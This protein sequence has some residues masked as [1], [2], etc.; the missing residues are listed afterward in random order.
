[1]DEFSSPS[2]QVTSLPGKGLGMV[3]SRNIH[4]GE[5]I[6]AEP[7]LLMVPWWVKGIEYNKTRERT[8]ILEVQLKQLSA[9]QRKGFWQ[10]ADC[11][12]NPG[13][14]SSLDGIWRTNN[15]ALG[16][17]GLRVDNGLF[18]NISRFNHSCCPFAEFTWN[19]RKRRQELRAIRNIPCG[20][21]ITISYFSLAVAARDRRGRKEYLQTNY[22]FPCDCPACSL[23]GQ[24]G[25]EDDFE[26]AEVTRLA[27]RVDTLLY[28]EDVDG[29]IVRDAS[30]EQ[31]EKDILLA[32]ALSWKRLK[33]MENRGFKVV[34]MLRACW[35]LLE[36]LQE[37]EL[38]GEVEHLVAKGSTF[39]KMLYGPESPQ[40]ADWAR[41]LPCPG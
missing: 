1:M 33:L 23:K 34:S 19:P 41:V 20:T 6:M 18:L 3:A 9:G 12:A 10:L 2:H 36:T 38:E 27:A 14:P 25:E 35:A 22:G 8:Q 5:L 16:A 29:G 7:P 13:E 24:E 28:E 21:E 26:R 40:A 17:S 31:E 4:P 39:A 32:V 37:W 11:K 30:Q 15:F